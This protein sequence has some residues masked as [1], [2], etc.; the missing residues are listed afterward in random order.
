MGV[1]VCGWVG[2]GAVQ[3]EWGA[4]GRGECVCA[5]PWVGEGAAQGERCG[6]VREVKGSRKRA[7]GEGRGGD[8]ALESASEK[9]GVEMGWDIRG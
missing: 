1:R 4:R 5:S 8:Y 3:G 2:E 7:R 6:W 9:R